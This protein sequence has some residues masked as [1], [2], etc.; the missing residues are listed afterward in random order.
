VY[1]KCLIQTSFFLCIIVSWVS[2][3]E[4]LLKQVTS[5]A[6]TQFKTIEQDIFQLTLDHTEFNSIKKSNQAE[7]TAKVDLPGI[8]G[9]VVRL[10]K[11][12]LLSTDFNIISMT[13]EGPVITELG[14]VS[15]YQGT[16][17]GV[18]KSM[19]SLM[20]GE[21]TM[22]GVLSWEGKNWNL[23]PDTIYGKYLLISDKG[24]MPINYQVCNESQKLIS[25]QPEPLHKFSK[26]NHSNLSNVNLYLECDYQMFSDF[27]SS[28]DSTV[29]FTLGLLN[30]VNTIYNSAGINLTLTELRVWT[31]LDPYDANEAS[32]PQEILNSLKCHLDGSYNGRIAHLISTVN[33]F[34]GLANHRTSCPYN[35]PL[36]GFSR[37]YPSYSSNLNIF[38]WSVNVIAHEIGHNLSAH[39]T[40]ACAWN[41]NNSQIDDCANVY[42]TTN[43]DDS[44]C[45]GLIDD[46]LEAEGSD[47][48]DIDNPILPAKG[49]IMSYCHVIS[50][51]GVDLTQGFHPQV[52]SRMKNFVDNCL[53][54]MI[55]AYCPL[56]DPDLINVSF[57]DPNK[58]Q[59]SYCNINDI[60]EVKWTYKLKNGCTSVSNTILTGTGPLTVENILVS[61]SY[62][63]FCQIKCAGTNSWSDRSCPIFINSPNC[64]D[65]SFESGENTNN[66]KIVQVSDYILS[67]ELIYDNSRVDYYFGNYSIL[68]PGFEVEIGSTFSASPSFCQ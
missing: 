53:S 65:I 57:H 60:S 29:N 42:N 41:G 12:K 30:V 19:L 16:I 3:Q 15:F 25:E 45:N 1:L 40:N 2:A 56:P 44:N 32:S 11:S 37:I 49:T 6:Q 22:T 61:R 54:P 7:F 9:A 47:C 10:E 48:F 34:G 64:D 50:G 5:A 31:T 58:M 13:K 14:Q 27:G 46:V 36:Y 66:T 17:E 52:A 33:K 62:E 18:K 63:V 35:R 67:N 51:V 24:N 55:A 28:L 23:V 21:S 68:Y 39:H 43:N 8:E 26:S 38:S 20:F 59:L 4:G